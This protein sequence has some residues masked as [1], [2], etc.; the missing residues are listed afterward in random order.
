MIRHH[1]IHRPEIDDVNTLVEGHP[2]PMEVILGNVSARLAVQ[3]QA[4]FHH[5]IAVVA[6]QSSTKSG[7]PQE[8]I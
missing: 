1:R 4:R 8:T 5:A 3:I 6:H 2:K 7:D